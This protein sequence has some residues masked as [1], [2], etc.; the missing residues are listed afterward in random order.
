[1]AFLSLHWDVAE[2]LTITFTL[3]GARSKLELVWQLFDESPP[4]QI[5][6]WYGSLPHQSE[7]WY[8][9]AIPIR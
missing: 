6:D 2:W 4:L 7:I 5:S 8:G 3:S 1:M 9:G